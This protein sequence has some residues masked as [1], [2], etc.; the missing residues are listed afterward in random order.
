MVL[1]TPYSPDHHQI[2]T[3]GEGWLNY[4][5]RYGNRWIH[6]GIVTGFVERIL[7]SQNYTEDE[8]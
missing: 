6:S 1:A 4:C 3:I 7:F 5:V 8:M 2:S